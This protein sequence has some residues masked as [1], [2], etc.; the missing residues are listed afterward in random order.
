[1]N[2]IDYQTGQTYRLDY[3][4]IRVLSIVD[5]PN[6]RHLE[7]SCFI[8]LSYMKQLNFTGFIPY[9]V[10]GANDEAIRRHIDEIILRLPVGT[11]ARELSIFEKNMLNAISRTLVM[12]NPNLQMFDTRMMTPSLRAVITRIKKNSN[13]SVDVP[14]PDIMSEAGCDA[15]Q[16]EHDLWLGKHLIDFGTGEGMEVVKASARLLSIFYEITLRPQATNE[17]E[18]VPEAPEFLDSEG[19]VIP[20][21]VIAPDPIG[22]SSTCD[23]IEIPAPPEDEAGD[24][25]LN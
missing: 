18:E 13:H 7:I 20:N 1:M 21:D 11:P 19:D 9:D 12:A 3:R 24:P 25:T 4:K 22:E 17:E 10:L 15:Y 8:R 2:T 14:F 16:C 23:E 5:S 6:E